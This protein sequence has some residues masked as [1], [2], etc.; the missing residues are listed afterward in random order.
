MITKTNVVLEQ[1]YSKTYNDIEVQ[2]NRLHS[3]KAALES[4][5]KCLDKSERKARTRTLIQLGGLINIT[6]LLSLCD[7]NLGDDLQ[8]HHP[9][10]ADILLGLLASYCDNISSFSEE[11]I[12]YFRDIGQAARKK[13]DYK[14]KLEKEKMK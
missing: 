9:D 3:Q 8:L 7:I 2:L 13:H 6:P 5:L 11:D 14:K 12:E 1:N 4:K 10:K